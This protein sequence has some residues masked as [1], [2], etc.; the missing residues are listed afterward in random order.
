M[1]P[2]RI[3]E[4]GDLDRVRLHILCIASNRRPHHVPCVGDPLPRAV[5]GFCRT[6]ATT[7]HKWCSVRLRPIVVSPGA[8][9]PVFDGMA[10]VVKHQACIS[11]T[12]AISEVFPC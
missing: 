7:T 8:K 10:A 4:R 9:Q 1:L 11:M 6:K 2:L 12:T 3:L 5:R